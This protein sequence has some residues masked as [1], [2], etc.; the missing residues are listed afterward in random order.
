MHNITNF[1]KLNLLKVCFEEL[2]IFLLLKMNKIDHYIVTIEKDFLKEAPYLPA[3]ISSHLKIKI[4][5]SP[6]DWLSPK[7]M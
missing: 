3:T 6:K 7:T 5:I 4:I 1:L 2:E